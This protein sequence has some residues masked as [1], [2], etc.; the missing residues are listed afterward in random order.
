MYIIAN[1]GQYYVQ[2]AILQCEYL[3][4]YFKFWNYF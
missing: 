1:K 4:K 3:I 2:N